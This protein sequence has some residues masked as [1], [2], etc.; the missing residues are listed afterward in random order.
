[1]FL[2]IFPKSLSKSAEE[3]REDSGKILKIL[4]LRLSVPHNPISPTSTHP[5]DSEMSALTVA[6][7][8]SGWWLI[9]LIYAKIKS[10]LLT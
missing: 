2:I 6:L 5:R 9:A 1:M 10:L 4:Q 8:F 3:T 7:N